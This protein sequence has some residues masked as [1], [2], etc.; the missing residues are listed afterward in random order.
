MMKLLGFFS[1]SLVVLVVALDFASLVF[2]NVIH[3]FCTEEGTGCQEKLENT[4]CSCR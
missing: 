3:F 4:F 1:V 2:T